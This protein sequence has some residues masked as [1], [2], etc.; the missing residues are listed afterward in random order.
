MADIQWDVIVVGAGIAGL[1]SAYR[2]IKRS[3]KTRVL[4]LEA[5]DR[6]GGRTL[7]KEVNYENLSSGSKD[8]VQ[9]PPSKNDVREIG[10][11]ELN[12]NAKIVFILPQNHF[13]F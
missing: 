13:V 1:S 6:V 12:S 2:I 4:V 10:L 11:L 9:K 3:P 5:N 8:N 7:S